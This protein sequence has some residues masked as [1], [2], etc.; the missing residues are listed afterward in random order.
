MDAEG[1]LV[2]LPRPHRHLPSTG[3][4]EL[5]RQLGH[6]HPAGSWRDELAR[7]QEPL[8]LRLPASSIS[9]ALEGAVGDDQPTELH[10]D[11][12]PAVALLEDHAC[13]R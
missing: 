2:R 9:A 5:I 3:V 1:T 8:L 10:L 7:L 13:S 12:P 11:P 6:C 4:A